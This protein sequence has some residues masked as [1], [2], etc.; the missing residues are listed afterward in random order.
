M[1]E[2]TE[3]KPLDVS[4]RLAKTY[5]ATLLRRD[6]EALSDYHFLPQPG[7][8]HSGEWAGVSF[9]APGGRWNWAGNSMPSVEL[10]AE[11]EIV[12]HAPYFKQVLDDLECVKLS[13][14]MLALPPG[15]KIKEHQDAG[16]GFANG[17][18]RLH[19]PIITDPRVEFFIGGQRVYWNAGELW[20]GDFSSV[21][22]VENRSDV[23]RYHLVMDVGVNDF[24]LSL[25][26]PEFV[27]RAKLRPLKIYEPALRLSPA[28][29]QSYECEFEI[30]PTIMQFIEL[31]LRFRE[32]AGRQGR[33]SEADWNR[34]VEAPGR[35][36][37][38]LLND[39]LVF[40]ADGHPACIFEPL[41]HEK[42]RVAGLPKYTFKF[43]KDGGKVSVVH[44]LSA[45][46][47]V[48]SLPV[49]NAEE[50]PR[51]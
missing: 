31:T 2:G 27:K 45:D 26:P 22:S 47:L 3:P 39:G 20:Y 51:L 5:D 43:E 16:F 33:M 25:F 42:L 9:V 36:A 30:P 32:A 8:H 29:L 34:V 41:R 28:E 44:L 4:V 10:S 49:R 37:V 19:I 13:V 17:M 50:A 23:T 11:T 6:M 1:S 14:R 7:V 15:G 48:V 24:V 21:H 18:L 35:G 46:D 38:R 12:R 40:L